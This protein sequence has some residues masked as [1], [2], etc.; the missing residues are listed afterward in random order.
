MVKPKLYFGRN[1]DPP[2]IRNSTKSNAGSWNTAM[3]RTKA[4]VPLVS[5][6]KTSGIT[7]SGQA[8]AHPRGLEQLHP[9]TLAT[10]IHL[11]VTWASATRFKGLTKMK[12]TDC[13]TK[14]V[15][16]FGHPL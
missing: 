12:P 8:G 9:G 4:R 16:F 7:L 13:W 14:S 2:E 1:S 3:V 10:T 6:A 15:G 5:Q 11:G